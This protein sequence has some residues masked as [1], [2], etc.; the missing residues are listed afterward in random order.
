MPRGATLGMLEWEHPW[1]H[2]PTPAP[3]SWHRPTPV[4]DVSSSG[5]S[6]QCLCRD[7]CLSGR[8]GAWA[9]SCTDM[10]EM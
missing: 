2:H 3:G 8:V 10:S 7:V 1:V 9:Q 6:D 5:G 4:W